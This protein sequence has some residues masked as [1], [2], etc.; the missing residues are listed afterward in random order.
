MDYF[1]INFQTHIKYKLYV[2]IND[3]NIQQNRW[4]K[5]RRHNSTKRENCQTALL[6]KLPTPT[7]SQ[8]TSINFFQTPKEQDIPDSQIVPKRDREGV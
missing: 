2:T 6:W 8:G 4:K 5:Q 7:V 1:N 3:Q